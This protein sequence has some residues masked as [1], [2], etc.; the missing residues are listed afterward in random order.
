[1]ETLLNLA[2]PR[3]AR[4]SARKPTAKTVK[5][6]RGDTELLLSSLENASRLRAAFKQ[7]NAGGGTAW[8]SRKIP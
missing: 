5:E 6:G 4:K 8:D 7:A 2:K 1:M 3:T